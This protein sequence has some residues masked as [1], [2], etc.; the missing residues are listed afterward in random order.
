MSEERHA[1]GAPIT[2]TIICVWLLRREVSGEIATKHFIFGHQTTLILLLFSLSLVVS[3][4]SHRVLVAVFRGLFGVKCMCH[5]KML[6]LFP[7]RHF[8]RRP[9]KFKLSF[10][11][12]FKLSV[13]LLSLYSYILLVIH[14]NLM[15]ENNSQIR[16]KIKYPFV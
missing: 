16:Y 2:T 6:K 7:T 15:F 8:R 4:K 10:K 5:Y 1:A 3:P 12:Q 14:M 11:T 9:P 13:N